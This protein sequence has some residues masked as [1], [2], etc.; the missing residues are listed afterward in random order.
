MDYIVHG[1]LQVKILEWVAFPFS[2]GSS[3]PGI[4]PRCPTSLADSLPAVGVCI[5]PLP[6]FPVWPHAHDLLLCASVTSF[7]KWSKQQYVFHR[8]QKDQIGKFTKSISWFMETSQEVKAITVTPIC[9]VT[10][11]ILSLPPFLPSAAAAA[12]F[13]LCSASLTGHR[14]F[15]AWGLLHLQ[16]VSILPADLQVAL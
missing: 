4:K 14:G 12:L 7:I 11:M 3:Q 2:R 9:I 15:S 13:W 16:V 8:F 6:H 5:L 10:T 1:I